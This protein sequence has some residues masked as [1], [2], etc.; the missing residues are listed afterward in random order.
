[1]SSF[2]VHKLRGDFKVGL[3]FLYGVDLVPELKDVR[4]LLAIIGEQEL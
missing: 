4:I 1:M 3:V 2:G